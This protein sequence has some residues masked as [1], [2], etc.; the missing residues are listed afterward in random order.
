MTC[1]IG[2]YLIVCVIGCLTYGMCRQ[3]VT[4]WHVPSGGYLMACVIVWL[5]YGMCHRVFAWSRFRM[6]FSGFNEQVFF[7]YNLVLAVPI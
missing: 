7:P 6:I 4:L 2:G 1:V 3:V 5:S